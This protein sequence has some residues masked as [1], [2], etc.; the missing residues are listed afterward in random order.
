[1]KREAR[2]LLSRQGRY[3]LD[4]STPTFQKE[5]RCPYRTTLRYRIEKYARAANLAE[6]SERG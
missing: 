4:Q 5:T 3:S 2:P 1:M 6:D